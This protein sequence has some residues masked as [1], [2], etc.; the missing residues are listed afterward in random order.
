MAG[1]AALF[2]ISGA[3]ASTQVV[4]ATIKFLTHLAITTVTS[5]NFGYVEAATAGTYTLN[6]AGL[7]TASGVGLKE[8][9]VEAAGH[10]LIKGSTSQAINISTSG[11]TVS[12][13]STPSAATCKYGAGV[14]T[15]C[16][17]GIAGAAPTAG[18]TSVLIG[19]KIVTTGG[20]DGTTDTPSFTMAVVYQ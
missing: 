17:G 14:E 4:T 13:A 3:Y 20:V 2:G 5:P 19:L 9:G 12:G 10:Y 6:T 15:A 11:Y 16:D 8:G 7:V 18:G 1:A